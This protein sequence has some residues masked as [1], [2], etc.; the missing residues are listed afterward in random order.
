MSPSGAITRAKN[1][2]RQG[3]VAKPPAEYHPAL[4][5]PGGPCRWVS[6]IPMRRRPATRSA[7]RSP[8]APR[9]GWA[10]LAHCYGSVGVGRGL[11]PDTGTGRRALR[12]DRPWAAPPRPQYR[13]GRPGRRGDRPLEL[14]AARH[15]R[16]GFYKERSEDMPIAARRLA[17]QIPAGRA[18]V[19]PIYGYRKRAAS[20]IICGSAPTARTLS[21]S[22]RPAAST[23]A[24]RRCRS[25]RSAPPERPGL[26]R[27]GVGVIAVLVQDDDRRLVRAHA[28]FGERQGGRAERAFRRHPADHPM[29]PAAARAMVDLMLMVDSMIAAAGRVMVFTH[30]ARAMDWT[31]S[32]NFLSRA[33]R[34]KSRRGCMLLA[35]ER[36]SRP[37]T[38]I[39]VHQSAS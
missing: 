5:R 21:T 14:A 28:R 9:P 31:A 13:R 4:A 6:P 8:T 38:V 24:T 25:R 16:L 17:S 20:P 30:L 7:G 32:Q 23:C 2:S 27:P 34:A 22:A 33:E 26:S 19:V 15:R 39:V 10:N 12:G 37:A 3:V 1:R 36:A 35:D 29:R 18:A 11:S